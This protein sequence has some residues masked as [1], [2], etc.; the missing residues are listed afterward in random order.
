[1]KKI[2]PVNLEV[3]SDIDCD[4]LGSRVVSVIDKMSLNSNVV[5]L[6][7]V[8]IDNKTRV[9]EFSDF[10]SNL[11]SHFNRVGIKNVIVVPVGVCG[12]T[13]ITIDY[14]KV[15]EDEQRTKKETD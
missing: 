9:R 11:V 6:V 3:E 7:K 10:C 15:V 2:I 13:D 5:N 12:V 4:D 8:H 1:M 14:I